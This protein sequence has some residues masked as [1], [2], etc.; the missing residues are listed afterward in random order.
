MSVTLHDYRRQY[1]ADGWYADVLQDQA[2][3][4]DPKSL[5]GYVKY[6]G[7]TTNADT[8]TERL[9]VDD[10]ASA[11]TRRSDWDRVRRRQKDSEEATFSIWAL[12]A[13][14]SPETRSAEPSF[15]FPRWKGSSSP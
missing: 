8:V 11:T 14:P 5:E 10:E 7:E 9:L 4:E 3:H 6:A 1:P 2:R 12:K 13:V 15:D